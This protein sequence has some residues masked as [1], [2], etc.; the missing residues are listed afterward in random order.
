MARVGFEDLGSRRPPDVS[1]ANPAER[2]RPP[3]TRELVVRLLPYIVFVKV[4]PDGIVVLNIVH[5]AWTFP[6]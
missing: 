3:G 6:K 5:T 2:P 1:G 4:V